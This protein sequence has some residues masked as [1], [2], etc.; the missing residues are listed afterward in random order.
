LKIENPLVLMVSLH[1]S[2]TT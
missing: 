1:C 2:L